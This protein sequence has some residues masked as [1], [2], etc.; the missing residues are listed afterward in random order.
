M[1]KLILASFSTLCAILC[2]GTL[3]STLAIPEVS[4][5]PRGLYAAVTHGSELTK[6]IVG[7][8]ALG[9]D[10]SRLRKTAVAGRRI[11]TWP[12]DGL[13]RWIPTGPYEYNNDPSNYGGIV[14]EGGMTIDGFA[15]PGGTWVAQFND[16]GDQA[17]IVAGSNGGR[18]SN[19]PGIVFRGSRWRG[20]STAPGF[21]NIY[22]GSNTNV[23][24]LYCEAGGLGA[25]EDQSNEVPLKLTDDT[26]NSVYYRNYISYTSTAIQPGSPGPQII[27]NYIEK[28]TLFNP[29]L[30]LNGISVNGGQTNA[31]ILRNKV[32]LQNPD[33][34]GRAINQTTAI[35]FFQDFGGYPGT[36]K[37]LDGSSGYLVKENYVGGGGYSIYAGGNRS[38]GGILNMN[39]IG[40][41]VTT[42]WWPRGGYWGPVAYE[43][44]WGSNGNLKSNNT[45]AESGKA[46]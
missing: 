44:I 9:V 46:W 20:K 31:L 29:L 23:W 17:I 18:S 19:L 24:V 5:V 35:G 32:L 27:E 41:Q 43:P 39:L 13:P 8:A 40:N 33:D 26:T 34:A 6:S 42:Q 22:Q 45:F 4:P 21:L 16:F 2:I 38:A 25:G 15:V 11:S 28:I 3:T 12:T 36:G 10:V 14:P 7:P 37:N 30:H 1:R